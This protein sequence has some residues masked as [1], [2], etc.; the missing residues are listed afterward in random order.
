MK[1]LL[2]AS[3]ASLL[4]ILPSTSAMAISQDDISP[5]TYPEQFNRSVCVAASYYVD[6][7]PSGY[8][9]GEFEKLGKGYFAPN[10]KYVKAFIN[11]YIAVAGNKQ[12]ASNTIWNDLNCWQWTK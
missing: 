6:G 10:G 8:R 12:A 1:K 7:I 9:F 3:F 5:T 11:Q 2:I 4:L